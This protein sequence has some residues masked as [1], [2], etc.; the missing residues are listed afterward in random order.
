MDLFASVKPTLLIVDDSPANL[1][2]LAGLLHG[3]YTVKAVNHGAKALKVASQEQPD[4]ILLDIMMP[5]VNGYDVC[6]QLKAYK[7]T[8]QIPVIF[9]TSKTEAVSEEIGMS[10]GAVDYITRPINPQI[11]LSRVRAHLINAAQMR[12]VRVNNEYLEFEVARRT[13]QLA[14]LEQVTILTMASL[15]EVRDQDTGNHLRRTQAYMRMLA[16]KLR[17][18]PRFSDYLTENVIDMLFRCT[19]LHD[20]GKVG[21][22]D[23]ILHKPGK[24]EPHEFE[25][26]KTHP[27]LGR[28]ALLQA[29]DVAGET[30]EFLEIA[31]HIVYSHHEKWDG[32]GYPQGLA[33]Q[34]IPIPARLMA[35]ADV[36]DA[37]ISRRVYKPG[38]SHA[39][40]T[41]IIVEGM[42]KH[43]DPDVVDAFL[44]LNQEFQE[45]A[46]RY[47]DSEQELQIK[48]AFLDSVVGDESGKETR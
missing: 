29:Q 22:P 3:A 13:R 47:A 19:P 18:H 38:M 21:I 40:A 1:T 10:L 44:D 17:Q 8:R 12:T 16:T 34:A 36:Y 43:F 48:A 11:L 39:K 42:G 20:I 27:A 15:A 4:L 6:R 25:I 26:M 28:D 35:V 23:R 14:A 7:H 32:S 2:L 41:G 24:Y 37:L 5:D 30:I 9:L 33:G 46:T 31:Q 45:I